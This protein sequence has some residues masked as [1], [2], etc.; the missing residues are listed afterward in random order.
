[1]PVRRTTGEIPNPAVVDFK[2]LAGDELHAVK[3]VR[4]C[5]TA[6]DL[7]PVQNHDAIGIGRAIDRH[8][9]RARDQ[10]AT[11]ARAL[12]ALERDGLGDR[13]RTESTRIQTVDRP[14]R[15]GLAD[16]TGKR[17]ARRGAAAR[18][19]VVADARD[20]CAG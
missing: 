19:D 3:A 12:T 4:A 20:P 6:I 10:N 11:F 13:H 7:Q 5:W 8:A 18:I 14:T 16:R 17:L 9:V 1:M 2:R 15:R